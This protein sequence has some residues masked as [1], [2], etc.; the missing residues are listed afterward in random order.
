MNLKNF[1]KQPLGIIATVCAII[2]L[3]VL[4]GTP[5]VIKKELNKWI[6]SHGPDV[7]QTDNVDFNPFTARFSLHNLQVKVKRGQALHITKAH[8]NF[9]WANLLK[10]RFY[11]KEVV[12][13]DTYLLVD[14]PA[15]EGFRFAGLVM[16]EMTD[17]NEE[18]K[19]S[20]GWSVAIKRF[21]IINSKIE[22]DT[23]KLAAT[24]HIDQ[25]ELT[26]FKSWEKEQPIYVKLQGRI[27]DSPIHIDAELTPLADPLKFKGNLKLE[28]AKLSLVS[29]IMA[30]EDFVL[31]GKLDI[32]INVE[33]VRQQ[34][35]L[36][37][38]STEGDISIG[39][40]QV[41]YG[42]KVF[43][44]DKAIWHG[45]I[46]GNKPP[47]EGYTLSGEGKLSMANFGASLPSQSMSV[48]TKGLQW[49]GNVDY[50]VQKDS[51]DL[52]SASNLTAA[53]VTVGDTARDVNLVDLQGIEVNT[54][55]VQSLDDM[56]VAEIVLQ[57]LAVFSRGA[58]ETAE[59]EAA[60]NAL[61]QADKVNVKDISYKDLTV[62]AAS[63]LSMNSFQAYLLHQKAGGWYLLDTASS[64]D[65]PSVE[66]EKPAAEP[67][68]VADSKPV[69]ESET[70][71]QKPKP[72]A[73]AELAVE[74]GKPAAESE[75][76]TKEHDS[77]GTQFHFRLGQLHVESE[78]RFKF[79]DESP[80]KP[81]QLEL[82]IEEFQLADIDSTDTAKPMQIKV[83]GKAGDYSKISING[84]LLPFAKPISVNMKGEITALRMPPLSS[85][86]GQYM[87]YNIT[88]G[89]LDA[90]LN[91]NIDKGNLDGNAD[92]HMRNLEVAKVDPE[93]EPEIDAQ[94]KRSLE[95]DLNM[96]RD[97]NDVVNLDI[98]LQGNIA[99]PQFNFQDAINQAIAKA[100]KSATVGFLKFVMGPVGAVIAVAEMAGKQRNI[101]SWLIP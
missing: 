98:K 33:T 72:V 17:S 82:H 40:L 48:Q 23:P 71:A 39:G 84:T 12:L 52:K 15:N 83:N 49:Q 51:Q 64:Q 99:N 28:Q 88:S 29:K 76:P 81:F 14:T 63:E 22:Y 90:E 3:V 101:R 96:L 24:Y 50:I 13:E 43:T 38:F 30:I 86:S 70:P 78:S 59:Q 100:M 57:N 85:Y 34:D 41:T 92:L 10:K 62:L 80:S 89:Q 75:R 44:D 1:T 20:S 61:L 7:A 6:I 35:K 45:T 54:I 87:G 26:D 66:P 58:I 73:E 8:L 36:I 5:Y 79:V 9:S 4:L 95:S 93:K 37:D 94:M 11:I 74:P 2:A 56:S 25:Y 19:S 69:V 91:T 18:E 68:S 55:D 32:D 53:G 47:V 65:T 31:E 97:K 21:E 16:P 27:D 46:S 60:Q 42:D 67:K 77:A